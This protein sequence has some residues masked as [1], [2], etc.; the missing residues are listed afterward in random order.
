MISLTASHDL[1]QGKE[2]R[3]F[4]AACVPAIKNNLRLLTAFARQAAYHADVLWNDSLFRARTAALQAELDALELSIA[5]AAQE[6]DPACDELAMLAGIA[7]LKLQ[8]EVGMLIADA[9]GP[10][11]LAQAPAEG[12]GPVVVGSPGQ[13]EAPGAGTISTFSARATPCKA[14]E[15][16]LRAYVAATGHR[17]LGTI[18]D[19]R[20]PEADAS[21]RSNINR[22]AAAEY[23]TLKRAALLAANRDNWDRFAAMGWLGQGIP[24][25]VGGHGGTLSAMMTVAERLGAGLAIEP[26][27]GGIVYPSQVLQALLDPPEAAKLLA[28]AV[29]GQI[30]LAM[31]CH[32]AAARGGL[33]WTETRAT[34]DNDGFVLNGCKVTVDGGGM[35]TAYLV[36]ARTSGEVYDPVG[37]SLFLVPR[38]APGLKVQSWRMIDGSDMATIELDGVR[39]SGEALLGKSGGALAALSAGM[40]A[41]IVASAFEV[42]GAMEAAIADT[43]L[44]HGYAEMKAALEQARSAALMGLASLSQPDGRQRAYATSAT[45][46]V[47][48]QA[49]NLVLGG[50]SPSLGE[51]DASDDGR[52]EQFRNFVAAANSHRGSLAFHLSRMARLL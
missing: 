50:A 28:P 31:A 11:G 10:Y 2:V 42:L 48:V 1:D 18:A 37:Q 7:G 6:S 20:P 33:R 46:A 27:T 36:S 51:Q 29:A 35:A 44:G 19:S 24:E 32:E 9:F 52:M 22:F 40:D 26:Y 43:T 30:R 39:V 47:V 34:P 16:E 49:S 17:K 3:G 41:A 38:D 5:R 15:V 4:L 25:E 45:K 8:D 21:L 23:T 14:N 13:I 12:G